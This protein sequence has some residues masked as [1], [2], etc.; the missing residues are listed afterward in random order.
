MPPIWKTESRIANNRLKKICTLL[1][2]KDVKAKGN[3]MKPSEETKD[4]TNKTGK[5]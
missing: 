5:I 1:L 3:I 4:P 2:A